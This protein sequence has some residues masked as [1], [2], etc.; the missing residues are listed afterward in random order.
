MTLSETS[1][2]KL[3]SLSQ[4]AIVFYN[5]GN[6]RQ[7]ELTYRKILKSDPNHA[8]AN[9][10][11]GVIAQS[12]GNL[13]AAVIL[14]R[15]AIV[16]SPN[17]IG[18]YTNIG[19]VLTQTGK[20]DDALKAYHYALRLNPACAEVYYNMA[21]SM[22][23]QGDKEKAI[24]YYKKAARIKDDYVDAN[25]NMGELQRKQENYSEA[26]EYFNKT[27]AIDCDNPITLKNVGVRMKYM[28]EMDDANKLYQRALQLKPDDGEIYR[29]LGRLNRCHKGDSIIKQ[30]ENIYK[31]ENLSFD[32][33]LHLCFALGKANEDI[34]NYEKSFGF[35]LE[36]NKMRRSTYDY[37]IEQDSRRIDRI[38]KVFNKKH[39]KQMQGKGCLNRSPI[40]IVG[41]PRSGTSLT[42]Q[43]LSSHS[44]VHGGGELDYLPKIADHLFSEGT[45]EDDLI[46]KLTTLKPNEMKSLGDEYIEK[47]R[48]LN[49]DK[50]NITDKMPANYAL[51]GLIF[52][53]LPHAKI[54]HCR[55]DPM[56]T[57]FSIFK[58]LF[59]QGRYYFDMRE[60]GSNY[61]LYSGMM[62]HWKKVLPINSYYEIQYENLI[63]D[64][65]KETR[66]L[67]RF[68]E[69]D[70]SDECLL[71]NETRRNVET[72]SATQ[73]RRPIYK[74]SVEKWLKFKKWL[75]P[76][77]EA[78]Q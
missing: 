32:K 70:W 47:I 36:G 8:E 55:R 11:L 29:E 72:A 78:L 75:K 77:K 13:E 49:Q 31:K 67:L 39:I 64:Q 18:Y 58:N 33:K 65:E 45:N 30:M 35:Y 26:V 14:F 12:S 68:C 54:V 28:G 48:A 25:F 9:N 17:N 1:N 42:E 74:E 52:I 23:C 62:E 34:G 37:H 60:I 69:L 15:K 73:V 16:N 19:N 51:I 50:K 44:D 38:R 6:F 63:Q 20:F 66:E 3:S 24:R 53:I 7:A 22:E 5:S 27:I 21:C 2:N 71:F 59:S 10:M 4:D 46:E 76:M 41:M 61:K 43:I 56:D 40:F 57:C